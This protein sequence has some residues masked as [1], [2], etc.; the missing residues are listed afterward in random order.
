M[1]PTA[2]GKVTK[3]LPDDLAESTAKRTRVTAPE[4]TTAEMLKR[5]AADSPHTYMVGRTAPAFDAPA[6]LTDGQIGRVS[7]ADFYGRFVVL[8][9]YPGDCASMDAGDLVEFSDRRDEF[10][11]LGCSVIACS[12]DSEYAHYNWR[13]QMARKSRGEVAIHLPVVSDRTR[14]ISRA[15][16]VLNEDE[17]QAVWAMLIIDPM[18]QIRVEMIDNTGMSRSVDETLMLVQALTI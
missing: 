18:Q 12:T 8:L 6:V 5:S 9:F 11:A 15:F 10:D 16:G 7:L 17:G 1:I 13:Q 3:R 2:V 4:H 14:R